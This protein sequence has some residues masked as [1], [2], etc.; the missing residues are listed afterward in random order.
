MTRQE[1]LQS[2]LQS[3]IQEELAYQ[4]DI[5]N[6]RLAIEKIRREHTGDSSMDTALSEYAKH[7]QALHDSAVIEQR[8]TTILKEVIAAQLEEL[9]NA[10]C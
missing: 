6:W 5:D 1:I 8:K 10:S 3:R 4:I 9:Q 2:A 7:L